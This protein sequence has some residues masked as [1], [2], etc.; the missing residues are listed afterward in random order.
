VVR[1][2]EFKGIICPKCSGHGIETLS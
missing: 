1:D 2:P